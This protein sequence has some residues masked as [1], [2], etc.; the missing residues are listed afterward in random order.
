MKPLKLTLI[1]KTD[2]P[3][4]TCREVIDA[5]QQLDLYKSTLATTYK[6]TVENKDK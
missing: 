6:I 2:D 5:L 3:N 4:K 1:L